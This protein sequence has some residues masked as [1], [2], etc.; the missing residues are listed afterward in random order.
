MSELCTRRQQT[1]LEEQ[2]I[3]WDSPNNRHLG[4]Q[5]E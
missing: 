3:A 4:R 2:A 1:S 5:K